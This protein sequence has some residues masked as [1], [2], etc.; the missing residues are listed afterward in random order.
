MVKQYATMHE[1]YE[2]EIKALTRALKAEKD[3]RAKTRMRTILWVLKGYTYIRAAGKTGVSQVMASKWTKTFLKKGVAG[4]ATKS[5]A[6]KEA[7]ASTPLM[8]REAAA[9]H[10]Q[11]KLTPAAFRERITKKTGRRY[12]AERTYRLLRH[13]GYAAPGASTKKTWK[14]G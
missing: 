9:L 1:M 4:L 10:R 3:E 5:N 6:K 8:E 11:G 13:M 14:R 12:T 7:L 2:R